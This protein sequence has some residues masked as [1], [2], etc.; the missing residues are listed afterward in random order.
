MGPRAFLRLS[1]LF[2]ICACNCNCL[3]TAALAAPPLTGECMPVPVSAPGSP[4]PNHH[5]QAAV[6]CIPI[7]PVTHGYAIWRSRNR[8]ADIRLKAAYTHMDRIKRKFYIDAGAN[9]YNSTIQQFLQM[10]PHASE[11]RV[12]AF[13]ASPVFAGEYLRHPEVEYHPVAVWTQ[14]GTL[15]FTGSGTVGRVFDTTRLRPHPRGGGEGKGEKEGEG[16]G[17]DPHP[18]ASG[19][20]IVRVRAIGLAD[21]LFRRFVLEDFVVL[22][23]DVEGAEY[24]IVRSLMDTGA[25]RLVDEVFVEWH[26]EKVHG[27]LAEGVSRKKSVLYMKRMRRMGWYCHEWT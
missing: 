18:S 6:G 14:N 10:Y 8:L 23:L 20:P 15:F 26:C 9:H 1:L 27:S 3:T 22:K 24:A 21:F 12:I 13:E 17:N 25:W 2:I 4:T 19:G 11:F 5:T 7:E 16:D